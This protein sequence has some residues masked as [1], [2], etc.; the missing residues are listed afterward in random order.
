MLP[1]SRPSR[2]PCSGRSI[3]TMP[4]AFFLKMRTA[5]NSRL[6]RSFAK[7][8]PVSSAS[9]STMM[10]SHFTARP[11]SM[12]ARPVSVSAT[13]IP[14]T[15]IITAYKRRYYGLYTLLLDC[16][17]LGHTLQLC[18]EILALL[19]V[20]GPDPDPLRVLLLRGGPRRVRAGLPSTDLLR[21]DPPIHAVDISGVPDSVL[22]R[23]G[24]ADRPVGARPG[25]R[26]DLPPEPQRR[27]REV[28]VGWRR[29]EPSQFNALLAAVPG[30]VLVHGRG[31]H[32]HREQLLLYVESERLPAEGPE[33]PP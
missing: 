6:S 28:T 16:A 31:A 14:S 15:S 21:T 27:A 7:R 17:I 26:C 29:A 10:V 22:V 18:A 12:A 25:L 33:A 11:S 32:G 23:H 20:D 2:I 4:G 9:P 24:H 19:L 13:S 3:T 5:T 30:A 8:G 1:G